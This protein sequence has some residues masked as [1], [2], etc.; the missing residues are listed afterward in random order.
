ME[1]L[2]LATDCI[3]LIILLIMIVRGLQPTVHVD[4]F[5]CKKEERLIRPFL[6]VQILVQHFQEMGCLEGELAARTCGQHLFES[7]LPKE[8]S[9]D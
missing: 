8:F 6:A 3:I 9:D 1:Y 4:S 2:P 7:H 5:F